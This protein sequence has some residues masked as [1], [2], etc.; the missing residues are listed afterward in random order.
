MIK[1]SAELEAAA[2]QIIPKMVTRSA[3]TCPECRSLSRSMRRVLV[4]LSLI[5][6]SFVQGT[7]ASS[8]LEVLAHDMLQDTQ[9]R[10]SP[11][12]ASDRDLMWSSS[13]HRTLS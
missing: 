1:L 13:Q 11:Q 12:T 5:L 7:T 3:T 8:P 6:M 9:G 10:Q 2:A 4:M